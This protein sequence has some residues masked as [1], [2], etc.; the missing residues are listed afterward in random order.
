[1]RVHV[2]GKEM[3]CHEGDSVLELIRRIG[4]QPEKV[5]AEY[6]KT[7]LASADFATTLLH[8]GDSLELLQFVGGG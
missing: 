3:D 8:E 1:M 4:L 6:N 7:L 2:N 5:V